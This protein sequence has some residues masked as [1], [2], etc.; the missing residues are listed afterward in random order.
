MYRKTA[1]SR[2]NKGF[3]YRDSIN[4]FEAPVYFLSGE[5]DYNC[6]Q[7]FV[8]DY[9]DK[10]T[11]PDKKFYL[12]SHAAHSPLWENQEESYEAMK[13]ILEKTY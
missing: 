5:Y 9:C 12:I 7:P 11:A 3:D 8:K 13:E 4:E 2:E 6:P 10:I 1:F